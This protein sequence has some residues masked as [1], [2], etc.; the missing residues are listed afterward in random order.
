MD[1]TS[2]AKLLKIKKLKKLK[3]LKSILRKNKITDNEE[4]RTTYIQKAGG[5]TKIFK[6]SISKN[7]NKSN[8]IPLI[9]IGNSD[10]KNY[11]I[12]FINKNKNKIK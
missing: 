2:N 6:E 12:S 7:K 11:K 3:L 1:N 5:G 9:K 10:N 4:C 8:L